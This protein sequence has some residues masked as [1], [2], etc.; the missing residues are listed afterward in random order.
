MEFHWIYL[1]PGLNSSLTPIH[2][3]IYLYENKHTQIAPEML[4]QIISFNENYFTACPERF[5]LK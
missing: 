5:E 3:A 1:F 2:K 4:F